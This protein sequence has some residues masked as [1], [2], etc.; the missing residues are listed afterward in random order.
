MPAAAGVRQRRWI[1]PFEH[2]EINMP[3]AREQFFARFERY[4]VDLWP[5]QVVLDA[6]AL[7]V[8]VLI[9]RGRPAGGRW[10]AGALALLWAWVAIAYHFAYFTAINPAAWVFAAVF[11]LGALSLTWVGVVP[12]AWAAVGSSAAFA[13]GVTQDLGLLVAGVVGLVAMTR[14]GSFGNG[15]QA[16]F[17]R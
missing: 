13:L 7:V 10:V 5:A 14:K 16:P 2:F 6:V 11:L 4:N 3:F 17:S 9:H 12:L 15:W 1:D 8:L